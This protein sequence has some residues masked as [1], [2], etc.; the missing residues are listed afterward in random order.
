MVVTL[1]NQATHHVLQCKLTE[2]EVTTCYPTGYSGYYVVGML[3]G[4]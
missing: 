4:W 1:V 2:T 3:D